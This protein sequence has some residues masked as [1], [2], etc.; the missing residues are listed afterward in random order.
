MLGHRVSWRA[1]S[2]T[3]SVNMSVVKRFSGTSSASH[4]RQTGRSR[5]RCRATGRSRSSRYQRRASRVP[6]RFAPRHRSSSCRHMGLPSVEDECGHFD[7]RQHL[8]QIGLVKGAVERVGDLRA[9][10]DSQPVGE[11]TPLVLIRIQRWAADPK[12]LVA[13]GLVA[14]AFSQFAQFSLCLSIF[15]PQPVRN[16]M[17]EHQPASAPC[18]G[19][20]PPFQIPRAPPRRSCSRSQLHRAPPASPPSASPARR[21]VAVV[22]ETR[23]ALVKQD[24]A[25]T[26]RGARRTPANAETASRRPDSTR[27][28]AHR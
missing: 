12:Q 15:D 7:R 2:T 23:P 26:V 28:R 6:P 1:R 20:T 10:T 9:G 19:T 5:R 21:S 22:G 24:Q 3:R 13:P 18:P 11:L 17:E 4:R 8:A 14:P 25:T 16:R 27:S